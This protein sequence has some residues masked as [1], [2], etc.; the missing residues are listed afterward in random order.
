[1]IVESL[2]GPHL[3]S[4]GIDNIVYCL[5]CYADFEFGFGRVPQGTCGPRRLARDRDPAPFR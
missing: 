2:P 5:A 1:M 3:W 4:W